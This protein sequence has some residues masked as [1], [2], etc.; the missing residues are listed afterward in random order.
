MYDTDSGGRVL[1]GKL[2]NFKR[3]CAS[4]TKMMT[5]ATAWSVY[6]K[7][8]PESTTVEIEVPK[9][10]SK[11]PGTTAN[12]RKREKL[13]MHQLF[14][15]MLLPSGNDAALTL[16]DFFGNVLLQNCPNNQTPPSSF[17]FPDNLPVRFF[18]KEM[19]LMA[20]K[21]GMTNSVYDSPHG[22]SNSINV[23]TASDQAILAHHCMQNEVFCQVVK[24]PFYEVETPKCQYEW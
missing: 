22:L 3:E 20:H 8:F 19:N 24:T 4:L 12:L 6:Q 16:A 1:H 2:I 17:Q 15:A 18:L 11:T 5:F 7:Y 10:C 14:Y 13:K 21:L 23:S 9:Y